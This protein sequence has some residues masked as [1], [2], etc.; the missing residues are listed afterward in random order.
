MYPVF[1]N[2]PREESEL[3]LIRDLKS[4]AKAESEIEHSGEFGISNSASFDHVATRQ[5]P[6]QGPPF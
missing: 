2:W 6:R 1:N 3:H 5:D 4:L